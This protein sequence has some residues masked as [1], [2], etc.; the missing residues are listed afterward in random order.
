MLKTLDTEWLS[1]NFS[2]EY[3]Q[4]NDAG[5][6]MRSGFSP[7]ILTM[8][9]FTSTEFQERHS[10]LVASRS[11]IDTLGEASWFEQRFG[12]VDVVRWL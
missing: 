9:A 4:W 11:T 5:V 10:F 8:V 6:E 7:W 2:K 3:G 1:A 12:M